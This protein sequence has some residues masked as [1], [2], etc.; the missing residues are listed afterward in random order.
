MK[1]LLLPLFLICSLFSGKASDTLTVRQVFDFHVGDTLDYK[2]YLTCYCQ[3]NAGNIPPNYCYYR[4]IVTSRDTSLTGDTIYYTYDVH[5]TGTCNMFIFRPLQSSY[6]HRDSILYRADS[7]YDSVYAL[8]DTIISGHTSNQYYVTRSSKPITSYG[9]PSQVGDTFIASP[10]L[11]MIFSSYYDVTGNQDPPYIPFENHY[12]SELIYY[13]NG[14]TRYG[15]PYD[16]AAG[17]SALTGRLLATVYP[18]PVSD[19]FILVFGENTAQYHLALSDIFGRIVYETVIS[20]EQSAHDISTLSFGLY[21]WR[22]ESDHGTI[23]S[24]KLIKQ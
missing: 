16:I 17:T 7:P 22:I 8:L 12:R 23:Q 15:I 9:I 2:T 5:Q 10:N 4:Y 19:R 24:G 1:K 21:L 6:S 11:G 20:S 14:S 18:N 3:A 13:A